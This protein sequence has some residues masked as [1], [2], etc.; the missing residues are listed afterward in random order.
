MHNIVAV[1]GYYLN[2]LF[3]LWRILAYLFVGCR[4]GRDATRTVD[5]FTFTIYGHV[6]NNEANVRH[7]RSKMKLLSK[8]RLFKFQK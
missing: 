6:K 5:S 2:S 4:V 3:P 8:V 1:K 7:W